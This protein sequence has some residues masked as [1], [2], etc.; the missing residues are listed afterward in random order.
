MNSPN[1]IRPQPGPQQDFLSSSADIVIYGGAAYGG[2]TYGLLME[3]TR[4]SHIARYNGVIFRR[5]SP[6]ITAGGGLWDTAGQIYPNMNGVPRQQ[7]LTYNFPSGSY[8]KFSHMQYESDKLSHQ[9]AQY[10]FIGFDELTHFT[11]GQFFYLLTRNRP[12][13]GCNLRPYCRCTCNADADS[14]VREF[15]N[16]WIGEDGLPIKERSGK[17]RYF[18]RIDDEIIWVDSEWRDEFGN[19]AKTLTFIPA[20]IHDNP[21]GMKA[22]PTYI[23]NLQYQDSVTRGRLLSGNWN[24]TYT[25][26]MFNPTWFKVI[27]EA[28]IPDG[29]KWVRYWDRAC[30]EVTK[31]NKEPDWT[32]GAKV[33]MHSGI[34]YIRDMKHFRE[35]PAKNEEIIRQTAEDD[36]PDVAIGFEQEPGSAGKD[37]AYHYQTKVLAG[38]EAHPDRPT[39]DKID[40]ARPWCALTEHGHVRIVKGP[41]N[42]AFLAE[43]GSFPTRKKDQID[44]VSGGYKQVVTENKVWP[45]YRPSL[46]RPFKIDF[47]KAEPGYFDV[48]CTVWRDKA[49]GIYCNWYFWGRES[50]ILR[51]YAEYINPVPVVDMAVPA[52]LTLCGTSKK[53]ITKIFS[54]EEVFEGGKDMVRMFRR[55]G[56]RLAY[57]KGYDENASIIFARGMFENQQIVVHPDCI[58]TDIEYRSWS[59][60]K[61]IQ[62]AGFF[63]C[64]GLTLVVQEL[65]ARGEL[66]EP[67]PLKPYGKKAQ[68]LRTQLK[69]GVMKPNTKRDENYYL[70]N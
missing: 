64:R 53:N 65:R 70:L 69:Y 63:L 35:S 18:T 20:N 34:L 17:L 23:S 27:Q 48:F 38:Y 28:D 1:D 7:G 49:T 40:R 57:P 56:L 68:E 37:V 6:Q 58:S 51:V 36:G 39:G 15:I 22:D 8:L 24:I 16:W 19:P 3:S 61:G 21:A 5:E 50:K 44:A 52:I 59:V 9:G 26:G 60:E 33:G 13:A 45:Q 32:A 4:Y 41:W 43:A 47:N 12:P 66:K 62:Q 30:S 46:R 2:K 42:R 29:I 14:W 25:G 67:E 31:E 10:V 11:E 54:N 55:E